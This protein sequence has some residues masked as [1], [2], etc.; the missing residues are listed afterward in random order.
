VHE[1][2][3]SNTDDTENI[4]WEDY[5]GDEE[6]VWVYSGWGDKP[7]DVS[8]ENM[9]EFSKLLQS[10]EMEDVMEAMFGNHVKIAA[11][12]SGFDVT[13]YDHD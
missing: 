1:P 4:N 9:N 5:D 2:S 13:D 11:T 8:A 6:G 12:R 3:F 10:S 7:E